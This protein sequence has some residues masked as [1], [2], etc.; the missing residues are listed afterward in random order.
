MTYDV[1]DNRWSVTDEVR[2]V[3]RA[4]HMI[5]ETPCGLFNTNSET[6]WGVLH[7]KSETP[8]GV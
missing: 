4:L 8:E 2:D 7:T 3:R 1:R 5:S 6:Q